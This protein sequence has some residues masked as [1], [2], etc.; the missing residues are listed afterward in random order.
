M[1]GTRKATFQKSP[2]VKSRVIRRLSTLTIEQTMDVIIMFDVLIAI[3]F[4]ND[5]SSAKLPTVGALIASL[6]GSI[7]KCTCPNCSCPT[8][9]WQCLADSWPVVSLHRAALPS[10]S[11]SFRSGVPTPPH[12]HCLFARETLASFL[13]PPPSAD[14]GKSLRGKKENGKSRPIGVVASRLE[15][16]SRAGQV[17]RLGLNQNYY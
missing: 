11:P 1:L 9:S 13:P 16:A 17:T 10:L 4:R 14:L 12:C 5:L 6:I 7:V 15:N 3:N 2:H 8:T